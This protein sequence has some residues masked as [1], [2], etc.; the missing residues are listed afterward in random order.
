MSTDHDLKEVVFNLTRRAKSMG[1]LGSV[2]KVRSHM[3][4]EAFAH[5]VERWAIRGNDFAD[6]CAEQARTGFHPSFWELW[7]RTSSRLHYICEIRRELHSLF[8]EIGAR[9]VSLKTVVWE[10]EEHS[11]ELVD[12]QVSQDDEV[13]THFLGE[14]SL[15]NLILGCC[16]EMATDHSAVWHRWFFSG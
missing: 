5:T 15:D 3:N 7:E 11:H 12:Q 8:T 4:V 14:I 1:V 6:K 10:R 2:M 13:Q 9:A 16:R